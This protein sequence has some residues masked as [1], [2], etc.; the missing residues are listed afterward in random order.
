MHK[1]LGLISGINIQYMYME[2]RYRCYTHFNIKAMDVQM[3]PSKV[4]TNV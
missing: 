3:S 4:Q 1:G 2:Q